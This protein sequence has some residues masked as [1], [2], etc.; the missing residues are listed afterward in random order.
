MIVVGLLAI[1][2]IVGLVV[3]NQ[4]PEVT[5]VTTV[6]AVNGELVP[7]T[8]VIEIFDVPVGASVTSGVEL[9]NTGEGPVDIEGV[10]VDGHGSITAESGCGSLEPR[11]SC[12]V[13]VTFSPQEPGE[14]DALIIVEHTGLNGDL[15][16]P[17]I[18]IAIEPPEAFLV[19]DPI[20]LEF[21]VIALGEDGTGSIEIMNAGDLDVHI[22]GI[23]IAS[24]VFVRDDAREEDGRC[25][26]LDPGDS[27]SID[28]RFVAAG[29]GDFSGV[30]FVDH[31][32]ENSPSEV[33]LSGI[34]R[35]PANL[36][37]EI[38]DSDPDA[39]EAAEAVEV[40]V[41]NT[42]EVDT[43]SGTRTFRR[44]PF[45]VKI[46]NLG[47]T[48]VTDRFTFRFERLT[49]DDVIP[50]DPVPT[51][52]THTGEIEFDGSIAPEETVTVVAEI[53]LSTLGSVVLLR[54]EVDSCLA[55]G[56]PVIPPCRIVESNEEDNL[57]EPFPILPL[58]EIG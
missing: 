28:V 24:D 34:V 9:V 45:T 48:T 22:H 56:S 29:P 17:V 30:L 49:G 40:I 52:D 27:C 26:D 12:L 11:E 16:I 44:V 42:F 5:V 8:D 47:Q 19:V 7:T 58:V 50:W 14:A 3:A 23:E 36:V 20:N 43:P 57:S 4:E 54:A 33:R 51:P 38:V 55:E 2:G 21:G 37:I 46:T 25:A 39:N 13:T 10:S 1:A 53:G 32:G 15:G 41:D 31:T 18:G 35:G 6:A